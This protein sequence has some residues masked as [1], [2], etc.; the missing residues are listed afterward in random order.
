MFSDKDTLS[1]SITPK[2]QISLPLSKSENLQTELLAYYEKILA[3]DEP[4]YY[5]NVQLN[6]LLLCLN[7]L[8]NNIND[9]KKNN[10][11]NVDITEIFDL[12]SLRFPDYASFGSGPESELLIKSIKLYENYFG[13]LAKPE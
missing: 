12:L 3:K 6:I 7:L 1:A 8:N 2:K 11:D 5:I 13:F 9:A 10:V 4:F